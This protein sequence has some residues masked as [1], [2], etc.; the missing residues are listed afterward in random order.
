MLRFGETKVAKKEFYGAKTSIKVQNVNVD[1][2]V[3][4]K[5]IE[6]ETNS[7]HLIGYLDNGVR[8]LVLIFP[9]VSGCI[10]TFK[11]KDRDKEQNKKNKLMTFRI[12]DEKL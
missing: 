11:V 3:D 1:N 8:P 9:K 6:T 7:K 12:D 5:L 2:I 10:K 4:S